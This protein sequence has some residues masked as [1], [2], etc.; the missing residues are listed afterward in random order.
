MKALQRQRQRRLLLQ[1][2]T[3]KL[4]RK[5]YRKAVLAMR[6]VN[7][8]E[9]LTDKVFL[10]LIATSIVSV[11]LCMAG[12][13]S[14]TWAWFTGNVSSGSNTIGAGHCTLIVT[15]SKNAA[16][17]GAEASALAEGVSEDETIVIENFENVTKV[18]SKGTYTINLK[19]EEDTNTS[20]YCVIIVG[21]KKY[22]TDYVTSS[23]SGDKNFS[24]DVQDEELS[25]TFEPRW[26]I[27]SG[28]A[29]VKAGKTLTV[30]AVTSAEN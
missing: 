15:V 1:R 5:I 3:L 27:Y 9:K 7:N 4:L 13:C 19:V 14:S 24:L 22:Y 18:L 17:D 26:G 10:R 30:S 6:K 20:G 12:L 28:E 21:E 2:R 29:D 8:N 11:I 16:S 25:V 23:D